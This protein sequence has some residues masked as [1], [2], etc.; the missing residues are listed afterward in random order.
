MNIIEKVKSDIEDFLDINPPQRTTGPKLRDALI[1][2]V[3]EQRLKAVEEYQNPPRAPGFGNVPAKGEKK[4][5]PWAEAGGP[6][7]CE[8]GYAAGIPCP[9]CD[10]AKK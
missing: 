8:H 4:Y 1:D 10:E 7:E 3:I 9:K 5:L 6:D 2:F